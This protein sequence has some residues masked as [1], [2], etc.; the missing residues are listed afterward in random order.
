MTLRRSKAGSAM[1]P[2]IL[3]CLIDLLTNPDN[4]GKTQAE[5]AQL[6]GICER[7]VRN[8]LTPEVWEE[9]RRIRLAVM[10]RALAIVDRAL[11][12]KAAN[13]DVSAAKLIYSRWDENK[14]VLEDLR[15]WADELRD[16]DQELTHLQQEI[17]SLESAPTPQT[18]S[19]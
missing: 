8:Y 19:A 4:D 10:A 13:G 17:A 9:I 3:S 7:T 16:I 11:F 15:P 14:A 2:A 12:A 5:I 1:N 18:P 6:A